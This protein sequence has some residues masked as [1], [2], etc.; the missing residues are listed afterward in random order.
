M[1]LSLSPSTY[2]CTCHRSSQPCR[3]SLQDPPTTTRN[4]TDIHRNY[5]NCEWGKKNYNYNSYLQ[6]YHIHKNSILTRISK[7]NCTFLVISQQYLDGNLNTTISG[8]RKLLLQYE[9]VYFVNIVH[10]LLPYIFNTSV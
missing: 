8:L 2:Q 5:I 4:T 10:Y 1:P 9:F 7:N 3:Q 6:I